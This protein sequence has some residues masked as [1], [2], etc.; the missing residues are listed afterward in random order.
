MKTPNNYKMALNKGIVTCEIISDVIYSFNKRAKNMRDKE[1]EYREKEKTQWLGSNFYDNEGKYREKKEG[2]YDKKKALLQF[3]NPECIHVVKRRVNDTIE[4]DFYEKESYD[5]L[6][7]YDSFEHYDHS[8]DEYETLIKVSYL[9]CDYYYFYVC[10][11]H[12]YH[13]PIDDVPKGNTL[14][15]VKLDNLTTSGEDIGNLLSIQFCN[16]VL[17]GLKSG[18]LSIDLSK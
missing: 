7:E 11:H 8:T 17:A 6:I 14:P 12:S 2:Y 3:L 10:G 18:E 9:V 4:E 1:R 16:K 5:G 15:I 13:T